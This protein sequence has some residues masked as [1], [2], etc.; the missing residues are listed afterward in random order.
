MDHRAA[1]E[2]RSARSSV[3]SASLSSSSSSSNLSFS[4]RIEAELICPACGRLFVQPLLLPCS[5]SM[6]LRCAQAAQVGAAQLQATP[7]GGPNTG[8]ADTSGGSSDSGASDNAQEE[9]DKL[10]LLSETDSG[11]CCSS[12][13]NSCVGTPPSL[14]N[15]S[16][17][18]MYVITCPMK[19]C[20]KLVFLDE[21]GADALP[22]AC[23]MERIVTRFSGAEKP[24]CQMC[25]SGASADVLCEQCQVLYCMACRLACHPDRGPLAK[26]TLVAPPEERRTPL[27]S[28]SLCSEH[29][30]EVISL[31]CN[32]CKV[33]VCHV[34]SGDQRHNGHDVQPLTSCCKVRKVCVFTVYSMLYTRGY[35]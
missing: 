13:P 33:A 15:L 26:H 1:S 24:R 30:E 5:H 21:R 34:C 17:A 2:P 18:H 29:R 10:S 9:G 20:K 16:S 35:L 32:V 7:P 31:F 3:S 19:F 14:S 28:D 25:E 23:A 4:N 22:R 8:H 6:C 27:P 11:V 12:R